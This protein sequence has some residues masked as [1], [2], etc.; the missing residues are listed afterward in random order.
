MKLLS[1]YTET[2]IYTDIKGVFDWIDFSLLSE[3]AMDSLATSL[4]NLMTEETS[5]G[6]NTRHIIFSYP[7]FQLTKY[8]CVSSK[9][10]LEQK[11]KMSDELTPSQTYFDRVMQIA[12]ED[13]WEGSSM[14]NAKPHISPSDN[15]GTANIVHCPK[16]GSTSIATINRGHSIVWGFLGSGKPV[17]VCQAC[18]YKFKPGSH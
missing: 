4:L 17:N 18:G 7:I 5:L 11:L 9:H 16:C 1:Q 6:Y 10:I 12:A 14:L 13:G 3:K 8:G 15:S 2:T